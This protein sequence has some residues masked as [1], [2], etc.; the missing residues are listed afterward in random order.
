[1]CEAITA[2]GK[3][4]TSQMTGKNGWTSMLWYS[5]ALASAGG[6]DIYEKGLDSPSLCQSF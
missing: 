3:V 4:C 1:M 2:N 5:Q 6:P